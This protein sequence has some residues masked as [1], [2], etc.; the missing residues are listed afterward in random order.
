M[1][2]KH[3]GKIIKTDIKKISEEE[4]L[5][6]VIYLND[7]NEEET[8]I[9]R[10]FNNRIIDFLDELNLLRLMLEDELHYNKHK[11]EFDL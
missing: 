4:S 11:K 9:Y 8:I 10:N 5:L 7:D 1:L 3:I 6:I 2:V